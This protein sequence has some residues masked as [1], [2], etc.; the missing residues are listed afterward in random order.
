MQVADGPVGSAMPVVERVINAGSKFRFRKVTGKSRFAG[1]ADGADEADDSAGLYQF[2]RRRAQAD[3]AAIETFDVQTPYLAL[4]FEVGDIVKT[5][6]DDR[7]I[8]STAA[9]TGA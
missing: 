4:G 8:F 9:I 7:D 6:P 2:V 3:S 5:N 1:A